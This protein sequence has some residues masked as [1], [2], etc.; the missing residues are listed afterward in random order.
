MLN[1]QNC[2]PANTAEV[3][4]AY[5]IYSTINPLKY[6][7]SVARKA[8]YNAKKHA[9]VE[10]VNL[11]TSAVLHGCENRDNFPMR[12]QKRFR[13]QKLP[14]L[15]DEGGDVVFTMPDDDDNLTAVDVS[16]TSREMSIYTIH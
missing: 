11:D 14:Q 12:L 8:C 2:C 6:I 9:V 13:T 7:G 5:H 16:L 3:I 10:W 1:A 4:T 15:C